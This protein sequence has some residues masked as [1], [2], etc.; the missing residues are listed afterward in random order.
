LNKGAT[1]S[2][3]EALLLRIRTRAAEPR[4]PPS[5][6]APSSV[7]VAPVPLAVA[8]ARVPLAVAVAPAARTMREATVPVATPPSEATVDESTLPP[9]PMLVGAGIDQEF[10][11]EVD[12]S[13]ATD[14]LLDRE[15]KRAEQPESR[16]PFD[17]QE[18]L[19]VA[20]SGPPQSI[21]SPDADP[22]PDAVEVLTDDESLAAREPE[23]EDAD[24]A[25][26]SSRRA[27]VSPSPP[28]ER[29][30]QLAFGLDEPPQRHTPPPKSGPLLAPP[31]VD[32]EADITG[33]RKTETILA[34]EPGPAPSLLVPQGV[35][36][37][38]AQS[39][40]VVDIIGEA[41]SFAPNT[42]IELL[43]ASLAL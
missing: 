21:P 4:R 2:K 3:L 17:S 22:S 35:R 19:A 33:V 8:V 38:L 9:P 16:G 12:L 18:R 42:F 27:V 1:L 34:E 43:D 29:L 31:V 25:P 28:E 24:E 7:A 20:E 11:V 37:S 36:P 40:D 10:A 6:L 23:E 39:V 32:F 14:D 41:Q 15:D 26:V 5:A 30:A 13:E